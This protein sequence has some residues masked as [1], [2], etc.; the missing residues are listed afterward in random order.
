MKVLVTGGLGFI[1]SETVVSLIENKFDVV[2]VDNLYNSKLNVLD[3]IK[4]I[5][6][7]RPTFYDVDV[8]DISKLEPV[9]K[10]EKID[11]IIHFA[12]Y[13]AVGE[14]VSKPLEYYE[15]NLC[16]TF[17]L[18]K[19]ME[20]YHVN[21]LVFSSSAT[22]YGLP[23]ST[24]IFETNEVKSAT[25]PYGESKVMIER[26]L[27]DVSVVHKEYNIALL[28]YFNPIGAHKS[29]LLGEDPNGIPNNLLPFIAKVATGVLPLITIFGNDYPTPD[30]TCVRD[31]VHVCDLAYGHVLAL[32]KL[33]TNPGLVVYN[34]GTGK[35]T[36]VLEMIKTYE[37]ATGIKINY[38]VGARRP[39]DI[40]ISFANCDK[41]KKELGFVC[42]YTIEDACRDSYNFQKAENNRSKK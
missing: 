40:P 39:G 17:A 23:D 33:T 28:R 30:G 14:S 41:A 21:N 20:K 5:T 26:V 19:C 2:V 29:G 34:L 36:S 22:V 35:G 13:K 25:S 10:K 42:K 15:N 24:P 27:T 18:L 4:K 32:N 6:G 9:F 7:V 8:S 37:K 12:G 31:Y 3:R 16:T 38:T 1:G 11:A